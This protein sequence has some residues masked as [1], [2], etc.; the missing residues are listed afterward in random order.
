MLVG[1]VIL[2]VVLL[3]IFSAPE[4]VGIVLP[5]VHAEVSSI[6]VGFFP[7]CRFLTPLLIL[8]SLVCTVLPSTYNRVKAEWSTYIR[9]KFN[10]VNSSK[11]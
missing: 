7:L 3:A 9:I 6:L 4:G 1:L 8:C 5:H 11:A 2:V 10:R